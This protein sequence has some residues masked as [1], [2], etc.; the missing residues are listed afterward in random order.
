MSLEE[1]EVIMSRT[2]KGVGTYVVGDSFKG[3]F[4]CAEELLVESSWLVN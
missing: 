2:P 1:G 3:Q 4:F